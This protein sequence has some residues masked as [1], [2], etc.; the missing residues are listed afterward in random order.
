MNGTG[1]A[2]AGTFRAENTNASTR[3][4]DCVGTFP[5]PPKNGVALVGVLPGEGIGPEIVD[6]ALAV[7]RA[8][9]DRHGVRL[10]LE[11]GSDIGKRAEVQHGTALPADVIG[12]CSGIFSRGG[13]VLSGA[14]GGRYV[15]DLRSRFDLF[16]KLSP[17]VVPGELAGAG[18][19]RPGHAAGVDVLVVREG[20][21]GLYQGQ[22][23]TTSQP[24]VGRVARHTFSYCEAHVRRVVTAAARI[25]ARR[26]RRLAVIYKESGA[27]SI[28]E[29]WRECALEIAAENGVTS[30][31]LDIDYSAY[32]L[33][34]HPNEFDV[35]VAPN[36]FGDIVS[37]LG[38][39]LMGSR[40][41]TYGG[42]FSAD[43]AAFYQTNHGA[44]YDLA[45]LDRANPVGQ[46]LSA[47]M[48]LRE[49]YGLGEASYAI[50]EA[51]RSVW[52]QGWRTAD[53]EEEGCRVAGTRQ[54][55][56]LILEVLAGGKPSAA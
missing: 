53:L 43:G 41:L 30:S 24:E 9:V 27:P 18:R 55:T 10:Q 19:M 35:I 49:S 34:Q 29:L 39:L 13:A 7:A 50:E 51:I 1:T 23:E 56:D 11:F 32:R 48:M 20:T 31:F 2:P 22:W 42:N 45:D 54:F 38:G 37:D 8:A 6:C 47:A 33:V 17:V 3:W 52:R 4:A 25:A 36:L 28:S 12:F 44:A 46:I 15:Y 21:S 26:Q 40:A 5:S 14:G 16:C